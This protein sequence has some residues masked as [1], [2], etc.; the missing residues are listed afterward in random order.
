[1]VPEVGG[2]GGEWASAQTP[3]AATWYSCGGRTFNPRW[4]NVSMWLRNF[5]LRRHGGE[6]MLRVWINHR[7]LL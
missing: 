7:S 5:R 2:L 1:V 4:R 6:G 3:R